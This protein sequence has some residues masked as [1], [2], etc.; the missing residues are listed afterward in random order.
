MSSVCHGG[1]ATA[2]SV[3]KTTLAASNTRQGDDG[4]ER[5]AAAGPICFTAARFIVPPCEYFRVQYLG[6]LFNRQDNAV[7]ERVG[8][9]DVVNLSAL[10]RR[11][12]SEERIPFELLDKGLPGI[13]DDHFGVG[14]QNELIVDLRPA[15]D[16]HGAHDVY[17]ACVAD[18]IVEDSARSYSRHPVVEVKDG[19]RTVAIRSEILPAQGSATRAAH[20]LFTRELTGRAGCLSRPRP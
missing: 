13:R 18:H 6:E 2:P 20:F 14:L 7:V 8:M 3:A 1:T 5:G 17:A 10:H 19:W 16:A 9:V 12:R 11:H 4:Q 15:F